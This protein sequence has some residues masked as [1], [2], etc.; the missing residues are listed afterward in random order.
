MEDIVVCQDQ[1]VR[2]DSG[3]IVQFLYGE[4]GINPEKIEKQRIP[5][6]SM[7][8]QDLQKNYLISPNE[9]WIKSLSPILSDEFSNYSSEQRKTFY[10]K[11]LAHYQE[12]LKERKYMIENVFKMTNKCD[13]Y[14]AV[15]I[16]RIINK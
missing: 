14:Y 10:S 9:N 13:I 11:M 4:D 6:I 5:S 15:N 7:N 8:I 16:V 2:T 12:I 1:T 3:N